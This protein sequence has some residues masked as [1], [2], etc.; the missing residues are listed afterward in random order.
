[1]YK[2]QTGD[3]VIVNIRP[4]YNQVSSTA[5]NTDLLINRT[6]T[7]VGSGAQLL[8]DAQVGGVS[9]FNVSNAGKLMLPTAPTAS[10]NYGTLSIGGGAFDGTTAGKFAGNASG[11]SLAVNEATG[12]TGDL[13]RLQI[14]GVSKAAVNSSGTISASGFYPIGAGGGLTYDSGNSMLAMSDGT[15][16]FSL[17][18]ANLWL[19]PT[20]SQI[21]MASD[22]YIKREAAGVLKL[23]YDSASPQAYTIK[24]NDARAG[25]D[26]NIAGGAL[27]LAGGRSTG[28]AAGGV[29]TFSTAPAGGSSGT[30]ANALV[31]RM[32]IDSAGNVGIGQVAPGAKL[33]VSGGGAF[34]SSY[35][36]TAVADGNLIAVS[37]THLTLPTNR[38]V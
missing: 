24:S 7:A 3:Q 34:G 30:A 8:I 32:R 19:R 23:G 18:I 25:T 4:T 37:Y 35:S 16:Q 15:N 20:A 17:E 31:E 6:E 22:I 13:M 1:M 14:A 2:R 33:S 11:T 21:Q 36:A 26:T 9:K 38:E 27:T 5:S 28:T 10:A 12:Y 29:L